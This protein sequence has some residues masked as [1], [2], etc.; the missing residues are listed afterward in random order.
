MSR[1]FRLRFCGMVY[2]VSPRLQ[3]LL[4]RWR[5]ARLLPRRRWQRV[6]V[7]VLPLLVVAW[8]AV[9]QLFVPTIR[10]KLQ[11]MIA[12]HLD[13]RLD[14]GRMMYAPPFGVRCRDVRLVSN[15]ALPGWAGNV[16]LL[17]VAKLDLKLARLPFRKG[18]LVIQNI[19]VTDPEVHLIRTEDGRIIGL[20]NIMRPGAPTTAT[21]P[22]ESA[23]ATQAA[24]R[25]STQA[26]TR[27]GL[28]LEDPE[29]AQ[30]GAAQAKLSDMFE[31]RHFGIKGGRIV[32][33]DR[34]RPGLPPVVWKGLDVGMETSARSKA[35]YGYT[36]DA[37]NAGLAK[38]S[39]TGAFDLDA[40]LVEMGS[41]RVEART[42]YTDDQSPLPAQVQRA[43]RDY[44]VEG[45]V[46][47]DAAGTFPLR[48]PRASVY[49]ATVTL[50]DASGYSPEWD[51]ALDRLSVKLSTD[52]RGG[53][54]LGDRASAER[55]PIRVRVEALD[56]ASGDT[57]YRLDNAEV[58]FDRDA[59]TWGL[60]E[61]SGR[62]VL[63]GER[64]VLPKQ[65]RP[66][67]SGMDAR[68]RVDFTLA[69]NGRLS[70]RPGEYVLAPE[71]VALLAYPRDVSFRPRNWPA[72]IER[73]GGGGT[74]RKDRGSRVV[75]FRNLTFGYGGDAVELT[76]AR[77]PLPPELKDLR[78]QTRLE[79]I[80]GTID[81]RRP[82]PPYP[83]G[84]GKVVAALRPVG[85]FAVGRDSWYSITASESDPRVRTA[86]AAP[87]PPPPAR[88]SDY[89]FSVATDAG[90][91][92]LTEKR[93]ELT[94]IT[95][96]ATVSNMLV[97]VRRLEA[98]VLGGRLTGGMQ[99]TPGPT[100][101]YQG[102]AHVR[103]LDLSAL[104]RLLILP[105]TRQSKLTGIGNLDVDF[106]VARPAGGDES[107]LSTARALGEFEVLRG[108]FWTIPVL[109]DVAGRVQRRDDGRQGLGTVGEAAGLFEIDRG[110][111]VLRSAAVS[112]PAL[113]VI[114]SGTIGLVGE[115]R[116]D[117]HVIAA[118]LGDW[119]DRVRQSNVPILSDVAGE[120]VGAVQR[121]VNTA[122]STLLYEFRVTGTAGRREIKPVPVPILTEPAALLF[123]RMLRGD[124]DRRLLET[125][126]ERGHERPDRPEVRR[127]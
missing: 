78:R 61:V 20:H 4:P 46:M 106:A 18:P 50:V 27:P 85:S 111:L 67:L 30:E 65:S 47:V 35:V 33:E 102:R 56:A 71:D 5:A 76:S 39:S 11:G 41:L 109:G 29:E 97:D 108:D 126:K 80:S 66:I 31:L 6:L 28:A 112:S 100:T 90:S 107:V 44:R 99:V 84:F 117:L 25:P 95:G 68:G 32:Y 62:V 70:A 93:L 15:A 49:Q 23:A 79:E 118:P 83:G 123:G 7:C 59:R 55:A 98:D 13:A 75:A 26:T 89:F 77:L 114:G 53:R 60:S 72:A 22:D 19:T 51:A 74:V 21:D 36:L 120:I 24:T 125:V 34:S 38:L 58:V 121:V 116:L 82:G 45:R 92:T 88:K 94:N 52:N 86:S 8:F 113:G 81:F 17:R 122:A 73:L 124:K 64:N 101:R 9:P 10:A 1:A 110:T 12:G 48:D 91:F 115:K 14:I 63:G 2:P 127:Q 40:L 69:A 96:D 16:E 43:L 119:R 57:T 3:G 87:R 103:G 105:Q 37:R 42:A 104:S 54:E